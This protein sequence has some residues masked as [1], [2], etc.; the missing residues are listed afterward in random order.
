MFVHV[1]LCSS[2]FVYV[3]PSASMSCPTRRTHQEPFA[4]EFSVVDFTKAVNNAVDIT[5]GTLEYPSD[6]FDVIVQVCRRVV[7]AVG[8]RREAAVRDHSTEQTCGN[9]ERIRGSSQWRY[10]HIRIKR[11]TG[12]GVKARVQFF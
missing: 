4:D 12:G 9:P 1:R 8:C 2:M 10:L 11:T 3:R 6:L 5:D 7:D